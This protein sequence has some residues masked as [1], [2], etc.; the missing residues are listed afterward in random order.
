[1][2]SI[3]HT[4]TYFQ[5]NKLARPYILTVT[6]LAVCGTWTLRLRRHH[7]TSTTCC[8]DSCS[9]SLPS[10][11]SQSCQVT[12]LLVLMRLQHLT[13]PFYLSLIWF[14]LISLSFFVPTLV[15]VCEC[16]MNQASSQAS[17]EFSKLDSVSEHNMQKAVAANGSACVQSRWTFTP[18]VSG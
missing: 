17:F 11:I 1:M 12:Y 7:L 2:P 3:T 4:R 5:A 10:N 13:L 16:A 15:A 9:L 14:Y 8:E 18:T 6:L